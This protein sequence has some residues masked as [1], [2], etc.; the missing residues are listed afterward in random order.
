MYDTLSDQTYFHFQIFNIC[1][2]QKSNG[3]RLTDLVVYFNNFSTEIKAH[4]NRN[5]YFFYHK[6]VHFAWT[7]AQILHKNQIPI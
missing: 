6:N 2:F 1:I 4:K 3:D 7:T 5:Y